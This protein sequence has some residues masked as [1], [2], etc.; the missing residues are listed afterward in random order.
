MVLAHHSL[1]AERTSPPHK[2]LVSR[3]GHSYH[4]AEVS[5][6]NVRT[7]GTQQILDSS[8]V[9]DVTFAIEDHTSAERI[10]PL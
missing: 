6:T 2:C 10:D 9:L 4:V 3:F 8:V 1:G 5:F 7:K